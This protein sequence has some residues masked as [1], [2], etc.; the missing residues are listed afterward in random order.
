MRTKSKVRFFCYQRET[1]SIF[2]CY[3]VI[4]FLLF[5]QAKNCA[6][7]NFCRA[8]LTYLHSLKLLYIEHAWC[9]KVGTY[10]LQISF[11]TRPCLGVIKCAGRHKMLS[12]LVVQLLGNH[13]SHRFVKTKVPTVRVDWQFLDFQTRNSFLCR[14]W[15][16]TLLQEAICFSLTVMKFA[17]GHRVP[18]QNLHPETF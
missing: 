2:A 13:V 18:K 6:E 17:A 16:T 7:G 10:M 4:H 11:K 1:S 12:R 5:S 15:P 8:Q 14:M 9:D 3:K